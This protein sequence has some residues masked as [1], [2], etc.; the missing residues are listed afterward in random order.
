MCSKKLGAR[1][2]L[3]LNLHVCTTPGT[4]P[5]TE[6]K[7]IWTCWELWEG[8]LNS[9][10]VKKNSKGI[11]ISIV[12]PFPHPLSSPLLTCPN[13][14]VIERGNTFVPNVAFQLFF[15]PFELWSWRKWAKYIHAWHHCCLL[16]KCRI[17]RHLRDFNLHDEKLCAYIQ[18]QQFATYTS[19]LTVPL[20]AS[21]SSHEKGPT[22]S[23]RDSKN[24]LKD[25]RRHIFRR[26]VKAA[27]VQHLLAVLRNYK[28]R[29][30][31][32]YRD[33]IKF[34]GSLTSR[35]PDF[36]CVIKNILSFF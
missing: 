24:K 5:T 13:M 18:P 8:R 1:G 15:E 4:D 10:L 3:L 36:V 17:C 26:P 7:T 30:Q 23:T 12:P 35:K 25:Q 29:P 21:G 20:R 27:F 11:F 22:I 19:P 9:A 16:S 2:C 33:R 28:K 31:K 34:S 6:K 32:S 14:R